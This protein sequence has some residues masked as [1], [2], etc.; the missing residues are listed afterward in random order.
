MANWFSEKAKE[1]RRR[2][3]LNNRLHS[4]DIRKVTKALEQGAEV[5]CTYDG[6]GSSPLYYA[7]VRGN[8]KIVEVLLEHGANPDF[9]GGA[10]YSP[11]I[12]SVLSRGY[13]KIAR[14][15]L[16][17]GADIHVKAS[18]GQ[19]CFHAAAAKLKTARIAQEAGLDIN[20]QADDGETPLHIAARNSSGKELIEFMLENGADPLVEDHSGKLALD[21]VYD[22]YPQV[23]RLLEDAML[24]FHK[25]EEKKQDAAAITNHE[26]WRRVSDEEIWHT[27]TEKEMNYSITRIFN[28]RAQVMTQIAHN[29]NTLAESQ[30]LVP[31]QVIEQ[32]SLLDEAISEMEKAGGQTVFA[33]K[34]KPA[35]LGNGST[36]AVF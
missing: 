7:A 21:R 5:D 18:N 19:T 25:L 15:L 27:A 33:R 14:R 24:K 10:D 34:D 31:F 35:R 1:E 11:I 2:R 6:T 26:G 4:D 8:E 22:S 30:T 36:G 23:K 13:D 28:F 3:K 29:L 12:Y 17:A 32:S 20:A 16:D 9:S